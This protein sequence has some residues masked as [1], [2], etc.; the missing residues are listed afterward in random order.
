MGT[1]NSKKPAKKNHHALRKLIGSVAL[2]G[3]TYAAEKYI[4]SRKKKKDLK[5]KQ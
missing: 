3:A 5:S 2:A 4:E 1:P